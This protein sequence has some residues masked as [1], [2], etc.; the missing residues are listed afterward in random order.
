[1]STLAHPMLLVM[2]IIL[3]VLSHQT[4][5]LESQMESKNKPLRLQQPSLIFPSSEYQ[6]SS[7]DHECHSHL[8]PTVKSSV[9]LFEF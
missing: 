2:T 4:T 3:E 8:N 6:K 1:M 7:E 5:S 9:L